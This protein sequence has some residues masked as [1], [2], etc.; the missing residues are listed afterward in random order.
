M[1]HISSADSAMLAAK[2][3]I[4]ALQNP[5]PAAPFA[6]VGNAQASALCKLAKIFDQ[7]SKDFQQKQDAVTKAPK[8]PTIPIDPPT[9]PAIT[10]KQK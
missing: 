8:S 9:L 10:E 6:P 2:D 5:A 3:L 7:A 4:A 1:P